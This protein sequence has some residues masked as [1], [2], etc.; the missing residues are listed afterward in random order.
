MKPIHTKYELHTDYKL[1]VFLISFSFPLLAQSFTE[2]QT[3]KKHPYCVETSFIYDQ[4]NNFDGGI[5]RGNKNL[6]LINFK[7]QLGTDVKLSNAL[8]GILRLGLTF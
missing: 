3:D 4:V 8:V 5:K 6:G 2:A 1:L 7:F